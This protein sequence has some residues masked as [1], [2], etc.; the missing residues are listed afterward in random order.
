MNEI[1]NKIICI[2]L[3]QNYFQRNFKTFNCIIFFF[4]YIQNHKIPI[5]STNLFIS[6]NSAS[7][8]S[9]SA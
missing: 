1:N 6:S 5:Y 9:K 7:D 4:N 8:L 3:K 2:Q